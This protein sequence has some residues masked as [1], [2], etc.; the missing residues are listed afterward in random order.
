MERSIVNCWFYIC[1]RISHT[2]DHEWDMKHPQRSGVKERRSSSSSNSSQRSSTST[3]AKKTKNQSTEPDITSHQMNDKVI[4]QLVGG[5]HLHT[6]VNTL[7]QHTHMQRYTLIQHTRMFKK[8]CY[9][10][11]LGNFCSGKPFRLQAINLF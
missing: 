10:A 4:R 6:H 9:L 7:V 2:N 11:L 8:R 1:R 5:V 3:Q